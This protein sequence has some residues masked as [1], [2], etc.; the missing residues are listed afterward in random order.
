MDWIMAGTVSRQRWQRQMEQGAGEGAGCAI[1][2]AQNK[3]AMA[4]AM[5]AALWLWIYTTKRGKKT[6]KRVITNST[7]E[8]RRYYG[9]D[10]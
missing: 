8:E 6:G 2:L 10:S 3:Y 7:R 1:L 9:I 4:R 5:W